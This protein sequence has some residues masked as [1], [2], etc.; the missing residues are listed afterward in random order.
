MKLFNKEKKEKEDIQV[1]ENGNPIEPEKKHANAKEIAKKVA[2][3]AGAVVIGVIAFVAVGAAMA[4]C[5][6]SDGVTAIDVG[7]GTI[8]FTPKEEETEPE[9]TEVNSEE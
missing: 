5:A 8:T 7:D 9:S 6:D 2:I 1:D 4:V 3:G